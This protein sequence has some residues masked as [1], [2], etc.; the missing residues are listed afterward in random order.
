MNYVHTNNRIQS[1]IVAFST[2]DKHWKQAKCISVC[3]LL[4]KLLYH[5]IL[6]YSKTIEKHNLDDMQ[7]IMLNEEN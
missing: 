5:R 2:V 7:E 4:T 3:D 1:F 6:F